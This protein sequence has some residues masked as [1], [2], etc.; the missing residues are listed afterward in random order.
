MGYGTGTVNH[1]LTLESFPEENKPSA[2]SHRG[3][4]NIMFLCFRKRR[5]GSFVLALISSGYNCGFI[6]Q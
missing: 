5:N 6:L 4:V 1:S 3:G 2:S